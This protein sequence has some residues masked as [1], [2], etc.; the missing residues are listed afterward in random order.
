MV[1][2]WT[3]LMS[4]EVSVRNTRPMVQILDITLQHAGEDVFGALQGAELTLVIEVFTFVSHH[5]M[6]CKISFGEEEIAS[7]H[8]ITRLRRP[9]TY[10]KN[11]ICYQCC[12]KRIM[13]RFGDFYRDLKL[14]GEEHIR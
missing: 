4:P 7:F 1:I 12:V 2:K 3:D 11:P 8:S 5:Y 6:A 14:D 9:V 10:C 13:G